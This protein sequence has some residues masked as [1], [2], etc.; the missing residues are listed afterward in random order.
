MVLSV[1]I[2]MLSSCSHKAKQS[3]ETTCKDSAKTECQ[4]GDSTK[5][6]TTKCK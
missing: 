3:C 2:I 1:A 5:V 6:D 4:K